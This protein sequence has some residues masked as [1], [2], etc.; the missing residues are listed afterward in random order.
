MSVVGEKLTIVQGSV[1]IYYREY[2]DAPHTGYGNGIQNGDSGDGIIAYDYLL[3]K[4]TGTVVPVLYK[5]YVGEWSDVADIPDTAEPMYYEGTAVVDGVTYN[6]WRVIDGDEFQWFGTAKKYIYTN[7][8]VNV[9]GISPTELPNKI[10]EV[11][12]AGA[13]VGETTI[14]QSPLPIEV[15][16]DITMGTLLKNATQESIGSVYKYTGI[17][18]STYENGALYIIAEE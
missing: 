5:T 2:I 8:I 17:T 6:K 18:T 1:T 7:V 11:Y 10:G 13:K 15:D 4:S 14:I 3:N 12:R 16:S 9:Q